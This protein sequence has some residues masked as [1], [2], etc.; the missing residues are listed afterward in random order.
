MHYECGVDK[1]LI[2]RYSKRD[3]KSKHSRKE[4]LFWEMK[5]IVLNIFITSI[6]CLYSPKDKVISANQN[7]FKQ[8]VLETQVVHSTSQTHALASCT[9]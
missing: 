4:R 1:T 9:C 5:L 3:S 6:L 2:T 7:N 8:I